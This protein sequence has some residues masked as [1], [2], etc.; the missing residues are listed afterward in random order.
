MQFEVDYA[1]QQGQVT[2]KTVLSEKNIKKEKKKMQKN[3][4]FDPSI[5]PGS[6]RLESEDNN[7]CMPTKCG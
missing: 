5:E 6:S 3:K 1:K 7:H 2:S 4:P